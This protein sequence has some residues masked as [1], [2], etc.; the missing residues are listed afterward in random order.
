M[1]RTALIAAQL[2][3]LSASPVFAQGGR[4]SRG[5]PGGTGNGAPLVAIGTPLPDVTV[6]DEQGKEFKTAS[7]RGSYTVLVFGCLT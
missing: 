6:F 7:L 4:P 3:C 5:G 1:L 2:I